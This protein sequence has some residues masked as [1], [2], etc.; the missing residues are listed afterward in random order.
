[1]IEA[2][3]RVAEARAKWTVFFILTKTTKISTLSLHDALPISPRLGVPGE[4]LERLLGAKAAD[5]P[6]QLRLRSEEHT[7]ELQSH[8]DLV[9]RLLLEKKILLR[10]RRTRAHGEH[11]QGCHNDRSLLARRRSAREVDCFFHSNEDHQD[12][13]S[14]PT[15]RSSDL[16]PARR[17]G[18]A[19]RAP[20]WRQ[21]GRWPATTPPVPLRRAPGPA[22]GSTPW[23]TPGPPPR[24]LPARPPSAPPRSRLSGRASPAGTLPGPLPPPARSAPPP[25]RTRSDDA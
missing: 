11:D 18:R 5:G 24:R 4:H 16:P 23:T 13:H 14:F 12:L 20:P 9:C 3:S 6:Q 10:R 17:A 8:S 22:G 1:M 7:S 19:P 21:G 15:R 25:A 2:F